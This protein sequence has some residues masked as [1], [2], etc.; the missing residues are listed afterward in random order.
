MRLKNR[1]QVF[2][3]DVLTKADQYLKNTIGTNYDLK[4]QWS[5]DRIYCSE[6][7]WKVYK[8]AA[9]I[10]LSEPRKMKSLNLKHPKVEQIIRKRYGSVDA[11]PQEELIVPP[12]DLAQSDLLCEVPYKATNK[13]SL[14]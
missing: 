11:L 13:K 8:K 12:S 2:N 3:K 6:L 14:K 4:F 7:V 1:E 10:E 9:N 5:D